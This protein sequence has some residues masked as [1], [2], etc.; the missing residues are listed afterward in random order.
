MK[1]ETNKPSPYLAALDRAIE[2]RELLIARMQKLI[3]R[4]ED[5]E[6][7]QRK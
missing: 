6:H 7:G 2:Q 1:N 3:D 4:F 5:K